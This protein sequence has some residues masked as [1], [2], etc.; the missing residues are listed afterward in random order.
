MSTKNHPTKRRRLVGVITVATVLGLFGLTGC[1]AVSAA[2]SSSAGATITV[3]DDQNRSVQIPA[4][5]ERAVVVNSYS[6]EFTNAIGAISK[7]VGTDKATQQRL[8]YLNFSDDQ[9]VGQSLKDLNYEAIAALNPDVVL[10]PRNGVWQDAIT[11]LGKFNIPVVVVTAWDYASF[12]K[13]VDL[14]GQIFGATDAAKK[15]TAFYDGIFQL[16]AEKVKG[17][18]PVKV[19]W[20]TAEPYLTVL[21]G[22]GF[23]AIIE[24]ANGTNVFKDLSVG[25][26]SEGEATVDPADVVDR[27]PAVIIHEFDPVATPTGD[28]KFNGLFADLTSRTGWN[29]ISAVKSKQVYVTNGWATSAVA[30]AI[31]AVY[32]A[33]WLHPAELADVDPQSY[34]K[35][36]V[37]DYQHT[38]L[39]NE[40]DYIRKLS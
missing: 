25:K 19:Y 14:L 3:T 34:L 40:S 20:E 2:S 29:Q 38:T 16:V 6:V 27:D 31:G 33:K 37:Q 4:N 36:W 7:V 28:T 11:Q 35:T 15:L 23:H 5:V 9:I 26:S 24:A 1:S 39:A 22:S 10:I 30:K 8:G 18:K 21:P 32:L 13:T 12:H 17:T